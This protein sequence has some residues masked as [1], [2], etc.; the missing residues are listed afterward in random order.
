MKVLFYRLGYEKPG[1]H[2]FARGC[3]IYK[4]TM[5]LNSGAISRDSTWVHLGFNLFWRI[6]ESNKN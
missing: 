5:Y 2:K 6:D 4:S 1:I 3:K